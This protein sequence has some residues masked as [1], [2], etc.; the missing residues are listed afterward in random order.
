M[1]RRVRRQFHSRSEVSSRWIRLEKP[2][3]ESKKLDGNENDK[4]VNGSETR[5]ANV[6]V[7]EKQSANENGKPNVSALGRLNVSPRETN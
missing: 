2:G 5:S 7:K 4:N 1:G 3:P 6:T